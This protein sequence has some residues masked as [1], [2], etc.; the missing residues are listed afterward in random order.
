MIL[1]CSKL[2]WVHIFYVYWLQYWIRNWIVFTKIGMSSH[3]L[4]LLAAIRNITIC[5]PMIRLGEKVIPFLG[6]NNHIL[7]WSRIKFLE[8][9]RPCN[10]KMYNIIILLA[11]CDSMFICTSHY[12]C[13]SASIRFHQPQEFSNE[14]EK[15]ILLLLTQ[16]CSRIEQRPFLFLV[17]GS[18]YYDPTKTLLIDGKMGIPSFPPLGGRAPCH[19]L[20]KLS[21]QVWIGFELVHL[22]YCHRG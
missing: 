20:E 15:H 14:H 21:H 4:C 5:G 9:P 8:R 19:C 17:G 10:Q 16:E 11:S 6:V 12:P 22:I 13:S 2:D 3:L 18:T 7:A 1:C